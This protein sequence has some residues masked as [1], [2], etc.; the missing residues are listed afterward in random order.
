MVEGWMAG[1]RNDRAAQNMRAEGLARC[2]L[3]GAMPTS[4]PFARIASHDRDD[5][6]DSFIDPALNDRLDDLMCL[7]DGARSLSTIFELQERL[8][9]VLE[10]PAGTPRG[11]CLRRHAVRAYD[12][13]AR[14]ACI[15]LA[16][17][18]M[19]SNLEHHRIA[20]QM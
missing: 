15:T 3:L 5:N 10:G 17:L 2:L 4:K 11:E 13:D 1:S 6:N 16:S 7:R 14:D 18:I 12:T 9:G 19:H 8:L 20:T